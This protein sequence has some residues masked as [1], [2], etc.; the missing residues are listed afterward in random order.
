MEVYLVSQKKA[1]LANV[2]VRIV[3]DSSAQAPWTNQDLVFNPRPGD[4][5]EKPIYFPNFPVDGPAIKRELNHNG[6]H[7]TFYTTVKRIKELC[8]DDP[9]FQTPE[10][11]ENL[12]WAPEKDEIQKYLRN[13]CYGFIKEKWND[14]ERTWECV[15]K[16]SLWGM[17]GADELLDNVLYDP[18]GLGGKDDGSIVVCCD[19]ELK[20][21]FRSWIKSMDPNA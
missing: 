9:K 7:Y 18:T 21:E 14:A 20:Y 2:R 15:D 16:Q 8:G 4:V 1:R 12:C 3:R 11:I 10:G 19:N 17:I 13:E 5:G 6:Y